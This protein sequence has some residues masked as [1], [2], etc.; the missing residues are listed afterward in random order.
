MPRD[1]IRRCRQSDPFP[2]QVS[3]IRPV[4]IHMSQS[5]SRIRIA[6]TVAIPP[7]RHDTPPE[8]VVPRSNPIARANQ[9]N[10]SL[11]VEHHM[12]TQIFLHN[13]KFLCLEGRRQETVKP[14]PRFYLPDRSLDGRC[15]RHH[16]SAFAKASADT[17]FAKFVSLTKQNQVVELNGIEPMTSSLQSSRSPN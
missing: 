8:V 15:A 3:C 16:Q 4:Q 1:G 5:R 11:H 7:K 10:A 2:G 14:F 9:R 13:V 17:G 12:L 6:V